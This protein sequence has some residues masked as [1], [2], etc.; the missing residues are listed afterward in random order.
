MTS[1]DLALNN[2]DDLELILTVL[3]REKELFEW[4]IQ[5]IEE[6]MDKF[7]QD[8]SM[9]SE[10]FYQQYSRG[11]LGD[12]E[13]FMIWAGEYE[14]LQKFYAKKER[15]TDLIKECQRHILQ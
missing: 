8:H 12:A 2:Q 3:K 10:E 15:L 5:K 6:K 9:T 4:E 7:E 1:I 11:D 14:F 13:V